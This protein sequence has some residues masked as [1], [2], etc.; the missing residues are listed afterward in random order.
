MAREK[1]SSS[2]CFHMHGKALPHILFEMCPVNLPA[3]LG[4]LSVDLHSFGQIIDLKWA[5]G[6]PHSG[7]AFSLYSPPEKIYRAKF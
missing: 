2:S 3:V 5:I 7:D 4:L 6:T 1:Q